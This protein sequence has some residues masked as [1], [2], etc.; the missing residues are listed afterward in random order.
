[1][2]K[3]A[4]ANMLG[5]LATF[6]FTA[7]YIPQIMKTYRTKTIDGVS[8]RLFGISFIANIVAL[9]Y[10]TLIGQSPLQIKYVLALIFLAVCIAMYLRIFLRQ[11]KKK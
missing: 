1:M 2:E 9:C 4:L 8:F 7:C 5:W 11:G 3:A 6:L 10:A